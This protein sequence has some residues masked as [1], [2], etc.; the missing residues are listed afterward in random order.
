M[1]QETEVLPRLSFACVFVLQDCSN[2]FL[3]R[4]KKNKLCNVIKNFAKSEMKFKA[5]C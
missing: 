1:L 4:I 2:L 3:L 5:F